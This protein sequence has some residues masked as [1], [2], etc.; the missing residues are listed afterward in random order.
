M[1]KKKIP[2][3]TV[4]KS[5]TQS[6]VSKSPEVLAVE[7]M[8]REQISKPK[9]ATVPNSTP[10]YSKRIERGFGRGR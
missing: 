10:G 7:K 8:Q 4:I 9:T 3:K 1:E 6:K 2:Q 5:T